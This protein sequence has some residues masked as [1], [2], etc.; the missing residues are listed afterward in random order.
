MQFKTS[1]VRPKT[2]AYFYNIALPKVVDEHYS[3]D[4]H[5]LDIEEI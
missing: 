1:G 2:A 4:G 5:L 3:N